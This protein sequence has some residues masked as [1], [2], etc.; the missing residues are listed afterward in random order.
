MSA[1]LA[2]NL[3]RVQRVAFATGALGTLALAQTR[4]GY[5]WV[6]VNTGM[7]VIRF[8]PRELD[9]VAANPSHHIEYALYDGTD[10]LQQAPLTWQSGVGA[11]RVMIAVVRIV[12]SVVVGCHCPTSP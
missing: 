1:T 3:S 10:G 8:H 9:R 12:A 4:E 2:A 6:G 5:L 11:V 7:S